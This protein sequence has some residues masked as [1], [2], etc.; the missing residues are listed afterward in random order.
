MIKYMTKGKAFLFVAGLAA[1][2][3]A[4]AQRVTIDSCYAWANQNYPLI[5]KAELISKTGSYNLSNIANGAL[6]QINFTGQGSYQSDVT[7]V[8]I[9]GANIQPLS[10][11]QYK[12]YTDVS[13]TIYAGGLIKTQKQIQQTVNEIDETGLAKDLYDIKD[14]VNQL[15]FGALAIQEQ[16]LQN[17]L[18]INQLS[19]TKTRIESAYKNGTAYKSDVDQIKATILL[20]TQQGWALQSGLTSYLQMLSAFTGKKIDSAGMLSIP[21]ISN[22]TN[23]TVN[24]R[25][26]LK[27]FS[28]QNKLYSDQIKLINAKNTPKLSV[29]GQGG[30]S[31]PG[32]NFLK[33]EFAL[34][35]I[36][37]V[38]INWNISSLYSAKK[39]KAILDLSKKQTDVQKEIF[40]FNNNLSLTQLKNENDKIEKFL[41]NDDEIISLKESIEQAAK[42]K[43]ENGVITL[44]DYLKEITELNKARQDKALHR[45]QLIANLYN[46]NTD[47]GK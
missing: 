47:L 31:K 9:P 41:Q 6:P 45:I 11:D 5:K 14:R 25:P 42:S 12:L 1:Y 22:I 19:Q 34:Y 7:A 21:V 44:N 28:L 3:C 36:G 2:Q 32:L 27:L 13:E 40:L 35:Y 43:Y 29:F 38:R 39:D 16:V 4:S 23:D 15:Y 33:N 30:Y 17:Q 26:E 8:A 24:N 37:G 10:K 20:Q 46:Q 18:L